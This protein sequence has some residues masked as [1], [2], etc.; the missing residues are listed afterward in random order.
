MGI[1]S[2]INYNTISLKGERVM[3]VGGAGFIGHHLALECR[4]KGAEVLVV[5]H[6]QINNIVNVVSDAS[7]DDLRRRLYVNFLLDRF[8]MLRDAGIKIQN[9]DARHMAELTNVF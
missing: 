1:Q 2:P 6:M 5:D 8:S 4:L 3:L 7:L 9:V